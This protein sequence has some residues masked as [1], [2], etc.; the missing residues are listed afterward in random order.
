[1]FRLDPAPTFDHPVSIPMPGGEAQT[2]GV[3]W[4]HKTRRALRD[5]LARVKAAEDGT[6]ADILMEIMAGWDA[7]RAFGRDALDA[8]LQN[9]PAA[10]NALLLGYMEGLTGARLGN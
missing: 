8:L 7:D 10:Q 4:T 5:W 1:M 6:E 2:L 9:Y 3:T